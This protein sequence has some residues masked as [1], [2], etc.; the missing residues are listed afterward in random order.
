MVPKWRVHAVA[1]TVIVSLPAP[2]S[3][4]VTT[5]PAALSDWSFVSGVQVEQMELS[6]I[7]DENTIVI[8]SSFWI[9]PGV[10]PPF[11]SVTLVM[12]GATIANALFAVPLPPS[13]FVTVTFREPSVAP[14]AMSMFAVTWVELLKV[15]ELTVMPLPE[16]EA[17]RP[18]PLA[19]P[20]PVITMFWL[21]RPRPLELG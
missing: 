19:N 10:L 13:G 1:D 17:A 14:L 8:V 3:V 12:V 21:V 20:L 4:T 15:V 9:V 11:P 18:A 16:N 5:L 2:P 6:L 7:C